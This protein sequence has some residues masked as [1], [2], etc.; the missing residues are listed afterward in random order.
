[1]V[2][3]IGTFPRESE[4]RKAADALDALGLPYEVVSPAG[5]FRLVAAPCVVVA[6]EVQA[7]LIERSG[8]SFTCSGWVDY[9]PAQAP[10]PDDPPEFFAEDIFERA[11]VMVLA[12]CTADPTKVRI[13]AHIS[14]DLAEVLPYLNAE[15]PR[16]CYIRRGPH[17]TFMDAQRMICLYP[18]RIAVAR[19]DE[20]VDAWRTLEAIRRRANDTW[21]RRTEITALHEMRQRPP[22][23][24]IFKRLPRTNCG[25]CGEQTCLA[26]AVRLWSGGGRPLECKPVFGPDCGHLRPAL[27]EICR[28]LG[29]LEPDEA[30]EG[31]RLPGF[32]KE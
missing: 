2:K 21:A 31:Q 15:M 23:L 12:P 8:D 28:G 26:F 24:E 9:R 10:Q 13:I 19:A 14:G 4:F 30:A 11:A 18:G 20:I 1:M 7:V 3:L 5:S 16:A 32:T 25:A 27:V 17:L 29:V 6:P 22:A